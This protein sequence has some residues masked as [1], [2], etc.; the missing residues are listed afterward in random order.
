M[1]KSLLYEALAIAWNPLMSFKQQSLKSTLLWLL[2]PILVLIMLTSLLFSLQTLK[3]QV[4]QAFDRTLAGAL[5]SIEVNIRTDHGGLSMEQPFYLFEFLELATQSPVYFRVFSEDGLTEVGFSI[6]TPSEPHTLTRTPSFYDSEYFG[7][8]VRVAAMAIQPKQGFS[9]SPDTRLIILVAEG[10]ATRENLLKQMIW[11]T[12]TRDLFTLVIFAFIISTG[13]IFA[14]RPLQQLSKKIAY[15]HENDLRP[16]VEQE[17]PSEITPL[18]NA[19]NTHM[20]R[21]AKKSRVQR[22]FLDDAS[23]QLR[24][25]LSVL[26]TQLGYARN[27]ADK[28][29]EMEEVLTAIQHRLSKTIDITNQLLTLA[30]V[31]DAAENLQQHLQFEILDLTE[32]TQQTVNELLPIAR[33]KKMDYGLDIPPHTIWIQGVA[34]LIKEALSNLIT[35]AIKYSPK[36]S[37]ITVSIKEKDRY[38]L[39]SVEDNGPGMSA[40]DIALAGKRFRRGESGREQQGS[41]LGLA[42]VQTIVE[43]N[44]AELLLQNSKS[45]GL[46]ASLKFNKP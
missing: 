3:N 1:S 20:D 26:N 16:I 35:N 2:L 45:G 18:V 29:S 40:E 27:L 39:L 21:Y 44:H 37:Q 11:Q 12:L 23:H 28:N 4:Q 7:E 33:R 32:L 22:Q 9:Y 34:W 15:R 42:I 6:P 43:I 10:V 31:Q 25:P 13:I 5:R 36:H 8:K 38:I 30:K 17:L 19:I 46:T 41:G 24:T 14:L